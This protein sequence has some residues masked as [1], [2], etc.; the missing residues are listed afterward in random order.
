MALDG[1]RH[2]EPELFER[3]ITF[4]DDYPFEV[5]LSQ[6][7]ADQ[8][9]L[10]PI[11]NGL[12]A[13]RFAAVREALVAALR[14]VEAQALVRQPP[15]WFYRLLTVWHLKQSTLVSFNYDTLV[16][17][18]VASICLEPA[19][20]LAPD[21]SAFDGLTYA[22]PLSK[23]VSPDALFHNQP[24][25]V[26][27]GDELAGT[28]M[29]LLKLHGSLGWWWV[30]GDESGATLAREPVAST[31]GNPAEYDDDARRALL[32]GRVPFIIPPLASKTA[33][34]GNPVSRQLWQD[35]YEA[36]R[37]ADTV[38]LFGYSLP[39]NDTIVGSMIEG[40]LANSEGMI[41]IVNPDAACL[42][43]RLHAL[44]VTSPTTVF[45]DAA[46]C[47]EQYAESVCASA[48]EEL[49]VRVPPLLAN[50]R[51]VA[52]DAAVVRWSRDGQTL[53]TRVASIEAGAMGAL[54]LVTE[55]A[56][57]VFTTD[58]GDG[59]TVRTVIQAIAGARR[60]AARYPDGYESPVVGFDAPHFDNPNAHHVLYLIPADQLRSR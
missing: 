17:A 2:S 15:E 3:S 22:T 53:H 42:E 46:R 43:Q 26:I 31:F 9:H 16:E 18:G 13:V 51:T 33:Y 20:L 60:I 10:G 37:N 12:N 48:S 32:P 44:G 23:A 54:T 45:D 4:S 55:T 11:D 19:E 25:V 39:R 7:A 49:S 52:E 5:W 6:L 36:L 56:G 41:E 14:E 28:T 27:P 57:G 58:P 24:P 30:E 50:A 35:A 59:P 47:A 38:A 21:L 34:Y 29:R 8:P 1:A 40:A